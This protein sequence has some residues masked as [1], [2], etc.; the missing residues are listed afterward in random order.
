MLIAAGEVKCVSN[1]CTGAAFV[2][3]KSSSTPGKTSAMKTVY[4]TPT[5]PQ[6]Y[7]KFLLKSLQQV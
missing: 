4:Y 6:N 2:T 7:R 3:G 1:N 5:H